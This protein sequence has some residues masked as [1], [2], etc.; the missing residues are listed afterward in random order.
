MFGSVAL[1]EA[2]EG[3]D[4]DFLADLEPGRSLLDLGGL[5]MDL[6]PGDR[7]S[8]P[9]EIMRAHPEVAWREISGIRVILAHAYFHIEPQVVGNVIDNDVRLFRAPLEPD[10]RIAQRHRLIVRAP[11]PRTSMPGATFPHT[12]LPRL[13]ELG[14]GVV[15]RASGESPPGSRS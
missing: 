6:R 11:Y 3:S 4:V 15:R 12:R 10:C 7:G 2:T 8:S 9:A 14:L 13:F 5:L 1:G